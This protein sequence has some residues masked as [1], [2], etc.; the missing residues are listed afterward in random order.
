[1]RADADSSDV[2]AV[3]EGVGVLAPLRELDE[4]KVAA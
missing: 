2:L 1:M 3:D 4:C